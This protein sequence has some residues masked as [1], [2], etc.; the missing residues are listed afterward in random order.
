M[1]NSDYF[2]LGF[3]VCYFLVSVIGMSLVVLSKYVELLRE[4]HKLKRKKGV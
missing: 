4:R 2:W 1:T 3:L